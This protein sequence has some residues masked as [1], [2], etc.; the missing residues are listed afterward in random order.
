MKEL[1]LYKFIQGKEYHYDGDDV[2]LFLD[3]HQLDEF[4][5]LLDYGYFDEGM[6]IILKWGYVCIHMKDICDYYDI[7]L[8]AVFDNET[9]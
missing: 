4:Q 1:K 8:Y 9:R 2:I 7:D 5:K 3:F 6:E